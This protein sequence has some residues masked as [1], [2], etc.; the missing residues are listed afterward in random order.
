MSDVC[1]KC[2][3]DLTEPRMSEGYHTPATQGRWYQKALLVLIQTFTAIFNPPFTTI[4]PGG[5]VCFPEP[6]SGTKTALSPKHN[7]PPA[8]AVNS[9]T[10]TARSPQ[11]A[12]PFAAAPVT[13]PVARTPLTYESPMGRMVD[14]SYALKHQRGD[15]ELA[16][17]NRFQRES[18]RKSNTHAVNVRLWLQNGHQGVPLVVE[19]RTFPYFHPKDC[20]PIVTLAAPYSCTTFGYWLKDEWAVSNTAIEL[21]DIRSTLFLRLEHV[22]ECVGGPIPKSGPSHVATIDMYI[23]LQNGQEAVPLAVSVT[24]HRFHPKEC[25]M[26][27]GLAEPHSC[28]TYSYWAENQWKLTDGPLEIVD[29]NSKIYLRLSHVT[30]C[31]D[32]PGPRPRTKRRLSSATTPSPVRVRTENDLR[33]PISP[34]KLGPLPLGS[35]SSDV[36]SINS[37]SDE[38]TMSLVP[39]PPSQPKFPLRYA[40]DMDAGFE[41]MK[42]IPGSAEHKFREAFKARW[43]KS[44]YHKHRAVWESLPKEILS[45][46]VQSGHSTDGEWSKSVTDK[47]D[48]GLNTGHLR[49]SRIAVHCP[50]SLSSYAPYIQEIL[51]IHTRVS[52]LRPSPKTY[53]A[54]VADVMRWTNHTDDAQKLMVHWKFIIKGEGVHTGVDLKL[55]EL[56]KTNVFE[57]PADGL[58]YV[59]DPQSSPLSSASG[60]VGRPEKDKNREIPDNVSHQEKGKDKEIPSAPVQQPTPSPTTVMKLWEG[61]QEDF[62][63][64]RQIF[65]DFLVYGMDPEADVKEYNPK[66]IVICKLGDEFDD[67]IVKRYH[68]LD[69][70]DCTRYAGLPKDKD[71]REES[72]SDDDSDEEPEPQVKDFE[73]GLITVT[74]HTQTVIRKAIFSDDTF[75]QLVGMFFSLQY[76]S[77]ALLSSIAAEN[78]TPYYISWMLPGFQ[79]VNLQGPLCTWTPQDRLQWNQKELVDDKHWL[80]AVGPPNALRVVLALFRLEVKASVYETPSLH[81]IECHVSQGRELTKTEQEN[82]AVVEYLLDRSGHDLVLKDIR[83]A[84]KN[85]PRDPNDKTVRKDY[86]KNKGRTPYLWRRWITKMNELFQQEKRVPYLPEDPTKLKKVSF[87][88]MGGLVNAT[89]DWV[90]KCIQAAELLQ[91]N[92]Q[93][94]AVGRYMSLNGDGDKTGI[95][96]LLIDVYKDSR[97]E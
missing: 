35:A 29:P 67:M 62:Y 76:Q 25:Q 10:V 69:L 44:T 66:I 71:V 49:A 37:S 84:N 60:E 21:K 83:A 33:P 36:I 42:S 61:S 30:F 16:S 92:Q 31:V 81:C 64:T 50:K 8:P 4:F 54:A 53:E 89:S 22:T 82:L 14:A 63:A 12:S 40:C 5:T 48:K 39:P 75:R 20:D 2:G 27:V 52:S 88:H 90:S 34:L 18:Y 58:N 55:A 56:L 87:V 28:N 26:I 68:T 78:P 77:S 15:Y 94:T 41:A 45:S 24:G 59:L 3:S 17:G 23:W 74:V 19:V 51:R 80:P 32:G 91:A 38:D 47:G 72:E 11:S 73:P 93:N 85:P 7:E 9:V 6:S 43:V 96:Q 57:P 95:D 97:S 70:T 46:A 86:H 13:S 1:P 65:W 79:S